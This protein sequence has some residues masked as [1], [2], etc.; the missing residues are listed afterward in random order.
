MA[1]VEK[2]LITYWVTVRKEGRPV[3]GTDLKEGTFTVNA[4]APWEALQAVLEKLPW[5]DPWCAFF[6]TS[7][8]NG[9]NGDSG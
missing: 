4:H 2:K 8:P 6:V 5:A 1:T 9:H 3:L 7:K